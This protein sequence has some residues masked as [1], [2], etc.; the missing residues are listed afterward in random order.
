MF[1][2]S[3]PY[4]LQP[5]SQS[6]ELTFRVATF[7][8]FPDSSHSER[9]PEY[10]LYQPPRAVPGSKISC[11]MDPSIACTH[12]EPWLLLSQRSPG[13]LG[14]IISELLFQIIVHSAVQVTAK[15]NILQW[16]SRDILDVFCNSQH[17]LCVFFFQVSDSGCL[18]HG[19]DP[20]TF[21]FASTIP[22]QNV[23]K[24]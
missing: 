14:H 22:G 15:V 18:Q 2:R 20:A 13:M 12:P 17:I 5:F 3:N 11:G 4:N 19:N 23:K 16:I 24:L 6:Y 1:Q 9:L 7:F 21:F 10:P 8:F